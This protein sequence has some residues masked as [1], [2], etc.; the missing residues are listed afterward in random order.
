MQII[1]NNKNPLYNN[2]NGGKVEKIIF[3]ID[4]NNAF[5]SW[6]AVDLM[7]KDKKE[8]D[9]RTIPSIIGG[10]EST[11]HGVVLA[12]SPIAK[13]FGIKAGE[14]I[15]Q[16]RMKCPQLEVYQGNYEIYRKYSDSL[17][18]FYKLYTDDVKRYSIDECALDMTKS[19]MKNENIV[20][21]AE[22]MKERIKK[23]Y[24]FT[25]NIGISTN[26]LLAKM[27]SDLKKPDR[28]HTLWESEIPTKM[29]NQPIGNLIG[30][31]HNS[32]LKLKKIG[33][34]TI[35][36]LANYNKEII[37]KKFGK[38]G[39]KIYESANGIDNSK[40]S[41]YESKAKG[42]SNSKT[43]EKDLKENE[44]MIPELLS[45]TE[46]VSYRLRKKNML[47]KRIGIQ[48]KTNT[49]QVY[50]HQ[51]II[52]EATSSTKEIFKIVKELLNEIN[53]RNPV[54]LLGVRVDYLIEGEESQLNIFTLNK[55]IKENNID[56]TIDILKNKYGFSS[57][58]R[59]SEL[60]K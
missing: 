22:K 5:L 19:I 25:V 27:A 14:P 24:G 36:D 53:I 49:F 13:E 18:R 33:I 16:A 30:V 56:K 58:K 39:K 1:E 2:K 10:D 37:I 50:T 12:K 51:K 28:V 41:Y 60:K 17:Y 38:Y 34:K 52:S 26:M 7:K 47:T 55:N 3:Y 40:G 29:W 15:F 45:I 43:L 32:E 44:Q 48:I 6:T 46:E 8:I 57:V 20:I 9:I 31:G 42:I 54:R 11:R 59:A 4:V 35:G 23:S 21:F